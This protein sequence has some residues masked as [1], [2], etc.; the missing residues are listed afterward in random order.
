[1]IKIAV[2]FGANENVAKSQMPEVMYFEN[3]LADVST[4]YQSIV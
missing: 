2:E 4:C 3:K 1:M